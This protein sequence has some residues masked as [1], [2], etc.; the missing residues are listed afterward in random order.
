MRILYVATRYDYGKPEQG[1]SFE[2]CNFYDCLLHLGNEILYFDFMALMRKLGRDRMNQRLLE[3]VRA[4]KPDLLLTMLYEEELDRAVMRRISDSGDTVTLNWFCDDHWRFDNFSR[5]WAPCLNW[6]VTTARSALPKYER[7]GYR[8]V[9]KSQWACNHYSYRKLGLELAHDVT[10]VGQ[11]HGNRRQIIRALREA[12]LEVRTWG[13]GWEQGRCTQEDMIRIFNQSRINLNLS[14]SAPGVSTPWQRA[15][16]RLRAAASRALDLTP[17]GGPLRTLVRRRRAARQL[18]ASAAPGTAGPPTAPPLDLAAL[19]DLGADAFS[20][21]IK[22]RNFE[23]PGCGGFM[24]TGLAEDL[25]A[26]YLPGRELV[27]FARLSEMIERIRYFLEHESERA[28]IAEA[29][30]Q[31]TLREHTYARRFAD[32]FARMGLPAMP[33]PG[34][35][36]ATEEISA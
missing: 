4:E 14:N 17:L 29:G 9:I 35:T 6:V 27:T 24:L 21:Q 13:N 30:Y 19:E 33:G 12:G 20:Q 16:G 5:F 34:A 11:P 10:F 28:A 32:V 3:V 18:P 31:R 7:M 15:R 36:G 1:L 2:H 8:N 25:E 26:Y 22:G 23:V